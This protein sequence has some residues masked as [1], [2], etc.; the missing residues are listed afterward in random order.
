VSNVLTKTVPPIFAVQVTLAAGEH[1]LPQAEYAVRTLLATTS[2]AATG[3]L[4]AAMHALAK[5]ASAARTAR[6]TSTQ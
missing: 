6:D 4:A 3:V 1:V 2:L 5:V